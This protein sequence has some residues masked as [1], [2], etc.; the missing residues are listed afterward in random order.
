M[1]LL[2][3]QACCTTLPGFLAP[4]HLIARHDALPLPVGVADFSDVGIAARLV[5][6][7]NRRA[8]TKRGKQ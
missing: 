4:L 1:D 7:A 5:N 2:P 3:V 6:L 8:A